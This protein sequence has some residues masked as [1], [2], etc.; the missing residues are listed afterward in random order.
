MIL[1]ICPYKI[2]ALKRSGAQR[3]TGT[4]GQQLDQVGLTV[5]HVLSVHLHQRVYVIRAHVHALLPHALTLT[6]G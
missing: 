3:L 2:T 1:P 6:A 4:A 5:Q